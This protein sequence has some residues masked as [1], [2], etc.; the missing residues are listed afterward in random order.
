MKSTLPVISTAVSANLPGYGNFQS[1]LQ[2]MFE[3]GAAN[4]MDGL[5]LHTYPVDVAPGQLTWSA[6]QFAPILNEANRIQAGFGASKP[7]WITEAG[8]GSTVDNALWRS[9]TPAQQAADCLTMISQA[10]ARG[11]VRAL[12]LQ[13]LDDDPDPAY[14]WIGAFGLYAASGSPKPAACAISKQLKGSLNC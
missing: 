12:Y 3:A 10:A 1:F 7:L 2:A 8:C 6:N 11:D 13:T 4:Y 5:G 14:G 9:I